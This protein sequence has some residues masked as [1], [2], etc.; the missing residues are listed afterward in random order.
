MISSDF[1]AAWTAT[2]PAADYA[3]EGG[4]LVGRGEGGGSRVSAA[5]VVGEWSDVDIDAVERR[6]HTWNQPLLFAVEEGDA[7]LAKAL[8]M[9]GYR[10][11]DPTVIL[12]SPV[13]PLAE[14]PIPPV[15]AMDCW[16]PLAIQRD[17]WA[18]T[19]IGPGRQA[20]IDRVQGPKAAILG[21]TQDRA[22]GV[23]FVAVHGGL[24]MLH[25]LAVLPEWRR[26]GLGAWMVR[27]A[28]RFAQGHGARELVLA[29]TRANAPALGLYERL[30]FERI[31]GYAYWRRE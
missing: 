21:R 11:A 16:P 2:W 14:P 3:R 28:A 25:A 12:S 19:G 13:A 7:A 18:R 17:L 1:D 20:V 5:R 24:G 23:G 31:G 30:G 26:Q 6:H 9:R 10:Q 8:E 22:A 29:A 4:F 15:K 27:R